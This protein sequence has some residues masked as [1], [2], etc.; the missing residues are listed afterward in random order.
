MATTSAKLGHFVPDHSGTQDRSKLLWI[1]DVSA[2]RRDSSS[3]FVYRQPSRHLGRWNSNVL[4]VSGTHTTEGIQLKPSQ[5]M[6]F[7]LRVRRHL[8]DASARETEADYIHNTELT[9]F[10]AF[11][12][13]D[14]YDETP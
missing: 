13:N 2:T 7:P 6:K 14:L 12:E 9:S 8:L 3:V 4:I 5:I 10:D 1:P 11:G